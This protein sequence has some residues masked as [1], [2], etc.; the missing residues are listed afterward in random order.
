MPNKYARRRTFKRRGGQRGIVDQTGSSQ[1]PFVA[2]KAPLSTNNPFPVV[3]LR[4]HKYAEYFNM[5]SGNFLLGTQQ[6]FRLNSVYDVNYTGAGHQPYGH[7]QMALLYGKYRVLKTTVQLLFTTPGAAND[8]ICAESVAPNTT[9]GLTGTQLW[10][11]VERPGGSWGHLP[12]SGDR[13]CILKRTYNMHT[14]CGVSKA[15]Y[16]A[17]DRYAADVGS[18]PTQDIL[19]TTAVG[20]FDGTNAVACVLQAVFE[21]EVLWYNR[22]TLG[23]S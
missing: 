23:S 6:A 11:P 4:K 13:R 2:L 12:T 10:E 16:L 17:E 21:F 8:M 14:I 5:S 9:S 3:M 19:L 18:N 1:N 7:D 20:C 15:A 22:T